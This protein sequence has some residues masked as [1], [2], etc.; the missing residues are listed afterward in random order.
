MA[1]SHLFL[2]AWSSLFRSISFS[3]PA[4][5]TG[6]CSRRQT[7]SKLKIRWLH[8]VEFQVV[9]L[10]GDR[11][12]ERASRNAMQV[13]FLCSRLF[14]PPLVSKE[15][16]PE[17]TLCSR[18]FTSSLVSKEHHAEVTLCSRLFTPSLVSKEHHPEITLCSRLFT[19]SLVSKE[20]HSEVTLCSRLFTSSLVSKEH[21]E[22]TL[23]SRLFTPSLVSNEHYPEVTLC[24]RL[25]TPSLVSNEH[26]LE[27]TLCGWRKVI[28]PKRVKKS[29]NR[30]WKRKVGGRG[31]VDQNPKVIRPWL[32]RVLTALKYLREKRWLRTIRLDIDYNVLPVCCAPL[33]LASAGCENGAKKIALVV[34]ATATQLYDAIWP[35][36]R[37][38]HANRKTKPRCFSPTSFSPT[39]KQTS[40]SVV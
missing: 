3:E 23:C 22:V 33:L 27:V 38:S 8:R 12:V 28:I 16:Y 14:T 21:A 11:I 13:R 29:Q 34:T 2:T 30:R 17:V 31:G 32:L 36:F 1:S 39:E 35:R 19:P 10:A 5:R 18:L 20:H 6:H 25:F 40:L 4:P 26:L 7:F 24:S 37:F 15:H 9:R